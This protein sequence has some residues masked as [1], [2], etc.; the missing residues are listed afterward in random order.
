MTLETI[1]LKLPHGGGRL[2]WIWAA[3]YFIM[4]NLFVRKQ[5]YKILHACLG[6]GIVSAVWVFEL[7]IRNVYYN[8]L[9]VL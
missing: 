7:I 5:K 4:Q 8:Q 2:G 1:I 3:I 6:V 9:V